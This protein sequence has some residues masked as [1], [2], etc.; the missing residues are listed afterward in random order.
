MKARWIIVALAISAAFAFALSVQGGRWW[1]IA[2]NVEIGPFNSHSCVSGECRATSLGWIGG[3]DRW[4]RT[5]IGAW[6]AGILSMLL[7]LANAAAV[8]SKRLP[9][10]LA[11]TALVAI[12]TAAVTGGLF[13][14]QFPGLQGAAVDRGLWLFAAAVV[15]GAAAMVQ[16]LRARPVEPA[17]Q[18]S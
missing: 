12:G 9:R 15:L 6:A 18:P 8:A 1:S 16:M 13:V 10:L 7:L 3:T 2:N 5:G 11:K 17:A 4:M 14:A